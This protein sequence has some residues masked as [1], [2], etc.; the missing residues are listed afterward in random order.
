M[1]ACCISLHQ[2]WYVVPWSRFKSSF[3]YTL[4]TFHRS[5]V[6]LGLFPLS[7][8]SITHPFRL[9]RVRQCQVT[10]ALSVLKVRLLFCESLTVKLTSTA[11]YSVIFRKNFPGGTVAIACSR[12]LTSEP[13]LL[14][15][16][17]DKSRIRANSCVKLDHTAA[18]S[19]STPRIGLLNPFSTMLSPNPKTSK[20]YLLY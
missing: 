13:Y 1:T 16:R 14:P 9:K 11:K 18:L 10:I 12:G 17:S 2:N 7:C 20:Q 4:P 15:P 19:P 8:F 3:F 6:F 5:P